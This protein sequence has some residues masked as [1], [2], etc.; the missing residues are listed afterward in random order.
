MHCSG[1]LR[2]AHR[3]HVG[4]LWSQRSLPRRHCLIR[5][6][7]VGCLIGQLTWYRTGSQLKSFPFRRYEGVTDTACGSTAAMLPS[8]LRFRA[9]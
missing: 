3:P 7:H 6:E 2:R 4:L 5:L 8:M 9:T 1:L